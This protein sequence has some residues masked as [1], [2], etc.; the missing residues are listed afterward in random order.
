MWAGA[1]AVSRVLPVQD[2]D[3]ITT[4]PSQTTRSSTFRAAS[5]PPKDQA[6]PP[7]ACAEAPRPGASPWLCATRAEAVRRA[8]DWYS[9]S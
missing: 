8:P 5:L 9:E 2:R 1:G 6:A 3:L 4:A 7:T